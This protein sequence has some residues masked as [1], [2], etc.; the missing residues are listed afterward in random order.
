M[1]G[2]EALLNWRA[3]GQPVN[4]TLLVCR[5][6]MLRHH[7]SYIPS[8]QCCSSSGMEGLPLTS[9]HTP[10]KHPAQLPHPQVAVR[11]GLAP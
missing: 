4:V 2:C 11:Q 6:Q 10:P 1:P 3:E 9:L 5:G 8:Q 7:H